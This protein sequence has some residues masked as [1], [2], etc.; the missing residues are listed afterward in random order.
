MMKSVNTRYALLF[1]IFLV[2]V[3]SGCSRLYEP[4]RPSL[5]DIEHGTKGLVMEFIEGAPPEEVIEGSLFQA[6]VKVA[7]EGAHDV[8]NGFLLLGYEDEYLYLNSWSKHGSR[9]R[10]PISIQGKSEYLPEGEEGDYIANIEAREI[11]SQRERADTNLYLTACYDYQTSAHT[12]VCVDTDIY[13]LRESEKAC[14]AEDKSLSSQGAPIAV[15]RVETKMLISQDLIK[16][17]FIVHFDNVGGGTILKSGKADVACSGQPL[18]KGDINSLKVSAALSE[19]KLK[20]RPENFTLRDNQDYV[21]CT[22]EN[23]IDKSIPAYNAPLTIIAE[24]G[25][26]E[27]VSREI[28]VIKV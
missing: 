22:H 15:T 5:E 9:E 21:I 4:D 23:G 14:D 1:V 13:D 10:I 17:Q 18:A 25:Y 20:C 12:S 26:M 24:Y 19:T 2:I 3:I 8:K 27:T 7:N 11:G 16:P 28:T 6:G